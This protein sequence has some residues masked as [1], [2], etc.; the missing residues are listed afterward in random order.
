M[1]SQ[2]NNAA[3]FAFF[4]MLSLVALIFMA[5][6]SGMIIFQIINKTIVDIINQYQGQYSPDQLKFAISAL[7]ISTPIF[8]IASRQI[9]KNLFTGAL[10]KESGIRKWLTYLILFVASVVMIGWLI[11]T[12]NSFLNGELTTKF[13]LKSITAIGIAAAIFTFYLYDIRRDEVKGKKDKTISLYFYGSLI[14][15]IAI[16]TSSL[17]FV[18]SPTETRNRKLDNNILDS[19][20]SIDSAINTYFDENNKL[21]DNLEIIK[22]EFPYITDEDL[23]DPITKKAY[24]YKVISER[25]YELCADFRSSNMAENMENYYKDMWPHE[26]GYQCLSQKARDLNG[27]KEPIPVR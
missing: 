6:S 22:N 16:F 19:F 21:P 5:L 25:N 3:K 13:I 23:M 17:F 11:A 2:N 7:I 27:I 15:I 10:E 24:E 1:E 4:Y 12:I 8:F 20:S 18:E 26:A 9:Y 14:I